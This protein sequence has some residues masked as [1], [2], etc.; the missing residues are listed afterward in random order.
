MSKI[1]FPGLDVHANTI[2]VAVAEPDGEVRSITIRTGWNR[3]ARWCTNWVRRS[4]SEPVTRPVPLVTC[5][6]GN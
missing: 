3:F 2:A 6:T 4:S 5:C 1:R